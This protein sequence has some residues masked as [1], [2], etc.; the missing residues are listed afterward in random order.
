VSEYIT[1]SIFLIYSFRSNSRTNS[2]YLLIVGGD[3]VEQADRIKQSLSLLNLNRND[4]TIKLFL[5][6]DVLYLYENFL[7]RTTILQLITKNI[8]DDE[9]EAAG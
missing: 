6:A 1:G 9:E 3:D 2:K 8:D 4:E 7:F 5:S